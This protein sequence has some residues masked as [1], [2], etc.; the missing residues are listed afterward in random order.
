[1]AVRLRGSFRG[2][3]GHVYLSDNILY[4]RIDL[5][6]FILEEQVTLAPSD[7]VLYLLTAR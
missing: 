2:P 6:R 7:R 4:R 5:L 1:M 3:A